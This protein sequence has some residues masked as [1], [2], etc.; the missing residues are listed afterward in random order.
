VIARIFSGD[1][2]A[3]LSDSGEWV[4]DNKEVEDHLNQ[5]FNPGKIRGAHVEMPFGVSSAYLAASSLGCKYEVVNDGKDAQKSIQIEPE[6]F[7]ALNTKDASEVNSPG[8][9]LSCVMLNVSDELKALQSLLVSHLPKGQYDP[10]ATK[11]GVSTEG[12][13]SAGR[14]Y[15]FVDGK[16][17]PLSKEDKKKDPKKPDNEADKKTRPSKEDK[18]GK[19]SDSDQDSQQPEF[20]PDNHEIDESNISNRNESFDYVG[21]YNVVGDPGENWPTDVAIET[22][23]YDPNPDNPDQ[24]LVEVHRFVSRDDGGTHFRSDWSF[25]YDEIRSQAEEYIQDNDEPESDKPPEE[26]KE[27]E[28]EQSDSQDKIDEYL[29]KAAEVSKKEVQLGESKFAKSMAEVGISRSADEE[30]CDRIVDRIFGKNGYDAIS[31]CLGMPDDATVTV[32]EG[33]VLDSLFGDDKKL[34]CVGVRVKVEHPKFGRV[35]RVFGIDSDGR[36]FVRNEVIEIK[37]QFQGDGIGADIFSKQV[38]SC[39]ENGIDYIETHAAKGSTMNGYATWPK[40][41]YDQSLDVKGV[42]NSEK[43]VFDEAKEKFPNA[44]TVLDLFET[45]EGEE[46]WSGKKNPDGTRTPG[47]GTDLR[48]AKFDLSEGSRSIRVLS[49]YVKKKEMLKKNLP[50]AK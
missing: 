26:D 46:W 8:Q 43:K 10:L 2:E 22:R 16:R 1:F 34:D 14:R 50:L 42:D 27:D 37:P 15:R 36:R 47:N 19:E 11:S 45:K 24:E 49:S 6:E 5:E 41:G 12:V 44:K 31:D 7:L 30:L 17:V 4:C 33:G 23:D 13:D 39:A 18:T 48:E 25:D 40:F 29:D 28:D 9:P 3:L 32:V 21:T 35:S 20:D 38:E